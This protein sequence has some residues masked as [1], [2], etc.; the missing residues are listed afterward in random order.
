MTENYRH[1]GLYICQFLYLKH[2]RLDVPHI[3]HSILINILT[4]VHIN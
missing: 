1:F 2:I 4:I 3:F